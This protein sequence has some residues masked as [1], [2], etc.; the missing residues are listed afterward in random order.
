MS[1]SSGKDSAL[2]LHR[3]RHVFGLDVT[4]LL[5]S[6]NAD[7]DRVSMHAVRS[8]LLDLQAE[9]LGLPV[10]RVELPSPCPN[11]T[12]EAEMREAVEHA[13]ADAATAMVFGDLFLGDV[14]EYREQRLAGSGIDPV[15]PLWEEPT[16]RLAR[17]MLEQ[18]VR[19]VLTCVDPRVLPAE[20]AGRA[21][22]ADLLA[23]LPDGVD[24]CGERGEFHTFVWDGPGF[25]AP[26]PIAV[27][28]TVER[29]GFV[30]CDVVPA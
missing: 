10:H 11:E 28:D 5:V 3:A 2:A 7:A 17:E 29:D 24:P 21:F 15:F 18:G 14:R 12:Y 30:F 9:R 25:S 26:V 20:F 27:G 13:R 16:D 1:W 6:V 23:D 8:E 4:T 22:D 19:A